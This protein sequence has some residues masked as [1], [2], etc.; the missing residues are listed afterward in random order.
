MATLS[1][2]IGAAG[3]VVYTL[4]FIVLLR[5]RF[6]LGWFLL[7]LVLGLMVH[8][9]TSILGAIWIPGFSYWYNLSL[10]AFLWFCF[11]FVTSIYSVSVTVGIIHYLY[12]R[13]DHSASLGEIYEYCILIPF[14][15]RA[16]FIVSIG[17]AQKTDQGYVSTPAGKL[18]VR[19]IRW[20]NKIL[21]MESK[22]FYTNPE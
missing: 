7:E 10:Y 8:V 1:F 3:F 6:R 20:I 5:L 17:Q 14:K 11:F 15:E 4:L 12:N 18:T 2:L 16:G 21:G 13:P 19:R 22:G 9:L